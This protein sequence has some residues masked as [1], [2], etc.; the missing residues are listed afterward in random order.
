VSVTGEPQISPIPQIRKEVRRSSKANSDDRV[1]RSIRDVRGI[2]EHA[3]RDAIWH[4]MPDRARPLEIIVGAILVQH[5]TWTNAERALD[6][7]RDAGTLDPRLLAATPEAEIAVLVRISGTP[8]VKARRLRATAEMIERAGGLDAFLALPLEAMRPLLL[9]THGIG[10]ETAD[11]IALYAA[12]R[13]T[14]VIDAYTQRIFGRLGLEPT[15]AAGYAA[16][17][18]LFE[19]GLPDDDAEAYQRYHGY[20]VLHA[21]ALCRVKPKCAPCPLLPRC[22]H[23]QSL[24]T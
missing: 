5:T 9:A 13:R 7:L 21:K 4:W 23:G 10:P 1:Q 8:S 17:Q 20:I 24:Q 6:A 11:A 12:R 19:E 2:L 22:P 16:W 18:R 3:Y 14:F 15:S